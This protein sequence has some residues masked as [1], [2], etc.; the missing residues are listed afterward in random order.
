MQYTPPDYLALDEL[1]TDEQR[2]VR[3]SVRKFVDV[4]VLP[5]IG[6]H[7]EAGTFPEH[8]IA[9]IA[10]LGVL[11]ANLDGYGCAGV[12]ATTYGLIMQE[13]ERGDSGVRSFASVQG[14]L[15]MFAIHRWGSEA[16]KEHWLPQMAAG[17][18]IGCFGL[19]EPDFGSNPGGMVTHAVEK[20]G[21]YVLNGTKMWITNGC[22]SKLAIVWAKLEGEIR[23]FIVETDRPGFES[24]RIEG[25]FSLR[26]SITSELVLQDVEIPKENLLPKAGGLKGPLSCLSQARYGV[27]WGALGAAMGCYSEALNYAKERVQFS[28]PIAG[29]QL[30]QRKLVNILDDITHGQ[31][32]MMR[33]ADLKDRGDVRPW[34]VSMGKRH[35]VR[36]ALEAARTTRDILG[37]N[38]ISLEYS[39]GRHMGNLESVYTYEGTHDIHTLIIGQRITGISAFE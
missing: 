5:I 22:I 31:L 38:G 25:K 12:D 9:K 18:A 35:C 20:G 26:A 1:L 6:Q 32:L 17:K 39:C 10:D 30:V 21:S 13:L 7:F 4:E 11:G 28:R 33:L 14:S 19:T 27:A 29:Y 16:Q 15:A 24:K 8:L 3:D 2:L 37:A 36:M 23:G 34:Q